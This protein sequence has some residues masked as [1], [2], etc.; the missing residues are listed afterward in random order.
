IDSPRAALVVGIPYYR[1]FATNTSAAGLGD[2]YATGF[3]RGRIAQFEVGS[4][5]TL[6]LPLEIGRW[7]SAPAKSRLMRREPS[8]GLSGQVGPGSR[9]VSPIPCS[10]TLAT[11]GL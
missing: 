2:V 7:G 8:L 4:S 6:G 1:V 5:V 9:Q 3:F 11:S 10:A